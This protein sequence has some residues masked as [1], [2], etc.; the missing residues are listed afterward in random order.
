M[1]IIAACLTKFAIALCLL[2]I[3]W[4]ILL[5]DKAIVY[6]KKKIAQIEDERLNDFIDKLTAAARQ[7]YHSVDEDGSLQLDYV[8]GMLVD[9]GYEITD[10]IRAKI[11]SSV[12][13]INKGRDTK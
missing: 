12:F 7:M 11:E 3:M 2:L 10:A 1:E 6:L 9:A 5:V 8:V 13:A 4:A